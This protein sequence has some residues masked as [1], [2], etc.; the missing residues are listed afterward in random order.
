VYAIAYPY[1][2]ML[3]KRLRTSGLAAFSSGVCTATSGN[4]TMEDIYDPY[5][6]HRVYII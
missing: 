4:E 1:H 5:S 3:Q 2:T 6:I